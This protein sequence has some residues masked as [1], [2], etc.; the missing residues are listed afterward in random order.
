MKNRRLFLVAICLGLL[1]A[2]RAGAHPYA[3]GITNQSGNVISWVLNEPVTDVKL[4]FDNGTVTNALG[5]APVVGQNTFNLGA[6]TNFSIVV[7]KVGS[8]TLTQ[9]SSDLN[10]FN[11]FYG[12][13]GVAVNQNARTW[14]FGRVY[15]SSANLG[16]SSDNRETTRGL[17]VLDAASDD[18]LNLGNTAAVAGI[19]LGTS[20][21]YSPFKLSVGP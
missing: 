6:H 9:I 13:R 15:V 18:I 11:N 21:T 12:P 19:A 4:L 10:H 20:T 8:N 16:E 7:F 5:S 17:Y 3:S 14:N 1:S 2:S